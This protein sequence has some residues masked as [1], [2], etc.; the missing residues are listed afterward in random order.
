MA[1]LV[2]NKTSSALIYTGKCDFYGTIL[3]SDMANDATVTI[4]DNTSATGTVIQHLACAIENGTGYG[5]LPFRVSCAT[6]IY[7]EITGTNATATVY[8]RPELNE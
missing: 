3:F 1:V 2:S 5:V 8:Y 6:G 7:A 4:Y